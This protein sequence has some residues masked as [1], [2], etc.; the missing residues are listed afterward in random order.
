MTAA[1]F[2]L[3]LAFV[4]VSVVVGKPLSFLNCV[5]IERKDDDARAAVAFTRALA[6]NLGR[7]GSTLGLGDWAGSTRVNCYETKAIWG[8]AISLAILFT[9]SCAILP[10]LWVKAKKAGGGGGGKEVA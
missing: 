4:I 1:D 2:L 8:F 5:L 3:L 7:A 6:Q 10:T 9:C